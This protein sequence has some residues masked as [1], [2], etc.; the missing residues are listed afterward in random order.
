MDKIAK[1]QAAILEIL[2]AYAKIEYANISGQNYVIADKENHRYQVVTL[3]WQGKKYVHDCPIHFDIINNK[4]WIQR[5]MTEWDFEDWF[6]KYGIKNEE[7]VLG[8]LSPTMR[9]YSDYAVA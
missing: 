9:S 8:F 3:G 6:R 1:Y 7:I 4:I 2:E 5:N